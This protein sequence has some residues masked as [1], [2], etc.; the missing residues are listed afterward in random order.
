MEYAMDLDDV[1]MGCA[2]E[3]ICPIGEYSVVESKINLHWGRMLLTMDRDYVLTRVMP[4]VQHSLYE[5]PKTSVHHAIYEAA[6][7]SYLMGCGY[8]FCTARQ[9]VESWEIGEAFPPYQTYTMYPSS[10]PHVF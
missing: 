2:P 10:Y 6:A 4:A 1:K 9:I 8:D 7:I 5:A 3:D